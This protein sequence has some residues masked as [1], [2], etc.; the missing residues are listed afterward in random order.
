MGGDTEWRN[1]VVAMIPA[2]RAFAWSLSHN[3]SD[4]DDLVQDTLIK[5]WSNRDKFEPGTNLRAWLF[6]ILRNTYYTQ[7]IRRRREV[8]DETGEYANN[9]RTPPTQDW[10][11]AMRA[12][13][14]G[15]AQLP[16][17]HRE[18]LILVGAAGLS[19]EEAAEICGCALGTIKSRVNRARARLLKIMDAEEAADV[20]ALDHAEASRA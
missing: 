1:E 5:A 18:A 16:D 14:A 2:L 4:A 19:Y 10:S 9:M 6:T 8:R 17:E 11:I 13:Q 15:L 7:V 12:L 20:M 3:G